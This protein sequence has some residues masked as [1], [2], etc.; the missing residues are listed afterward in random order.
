LKTLLAVIAL[1]LALGALGAVG[2]SYILRDRQVEEL[3]DAISTL[4]ARLAAAEQLSREA[5]TASETATLPQSVE[6]NLAELQEKFDAIGK[7]VEIMGTQVSALREAEKKSKLQFA[8]FRD[9]VGKM[10]ESPGGAVPKEEI[11]SMINEKLKDG[12]LGKK[13]A[14]SAVAARIELEKDEQAAIED[15]LHR[16]K[17]E[18][19]SILKTPRDDGSNL[20]DEFADELIEIY[21]S[22]QPDAGAAVKAYMKLFGRLATE[23]V[24]GS[25]ET[26]L[27]RLGKIE[28]ETRTAYRDT[29]SEKKYSAFEALG[30]ENTTEIKIP[31][32]PIDK[33][34]QQRLEAAGAGTEK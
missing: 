4:D 16:K 3:R 10:S 23:K 28:Q 5:K 22:E 34:V 14:L 29:L 30:I 9:K 32:E 12:H 6:D 33:Y 24:P 17:L 11:E 8:R 18:V 31:D 19:M 7:R 15:I 13:P 26:Y 2:Y 25:S 1:I 20:L 21:S 27:S